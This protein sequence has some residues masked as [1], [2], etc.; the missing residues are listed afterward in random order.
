MTERLI[1][2]QL[3]ELQV[4][5]NQAVAGANIAFLDQPQ[6]RT[7]QGKMVYLHSIEC[8]SAAAV[9]VSPLSALPVAA[10]T[11]LQ[12]AFLTLVTV[13]RR[14]ILNFPLIALNRIFDPGAVVPHVRDLQLL[15]YL[16]E[17]SWAESYV[18]LAAAGTATAF[19]YLF[20]IGY[21]T[22]LASPPYPGT[23]PFPI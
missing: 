11:D 17:V 10:G 14:D 15:N 2:S 19:T 12:N 20:N 5:A 16:S 1:K 6:L 8:Y 22:E 7:Q 23:Q 18:S 9:P 3:V 4:I 13:G 21:T